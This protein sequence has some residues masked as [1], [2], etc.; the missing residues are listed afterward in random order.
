MAGGFHRFHG[1]WG[2]A[3]TLTPGTV[4]RGVAKE[5]PVLSPQNPPKPLLHPRAAVPPCLQGPDQAVPGALISPRPAP[6]PLE[7]LAPTLSS[8]ALRLRGRPESW[9]MVELLLRQL[10][11]S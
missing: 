8:S 1:S 6:S 11:P 2:L 3:E 10:L 5:M 9:L 4:S 7:T